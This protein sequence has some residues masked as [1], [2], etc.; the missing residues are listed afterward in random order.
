[1]SLIGILSS[2]LKILNIHK[3][4]EFFSSCFQVS[5]TQVMNKRCHNSCLSIILLDKSCCCS[6][7][8]VYFVNV[9]LSKG[10]QTVKGYSKNGLTI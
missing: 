2:S 9:F 6:F 5:P 8:F 3:N 7:H 4:L 1:M 10:V